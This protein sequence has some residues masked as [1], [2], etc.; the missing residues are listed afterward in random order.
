MEQYPNCHLCC[1]NVLWVTQDGESMHRTWPD[2]PHKTGIYSP[3]GFVNIAILEFFHINSM[4]V[5][6]EDY[7]TYVS[8]PLEFKM[9][10]NKEADD[11]P[12]LLYMAQLGDTYYIS[13]TM[14]HYRP[15]SNEFAASLKMKSTADFM[16]VTETRLQALKA[17]DKY[18]QYKFHDA[19]F[20]YQQQQEIRKAAL[21]GQYKLCLNIG[22]K[23]VFREA[24]SNKRWRLKIYIG[25]YFPWLIAIYDKKKRKKQNATG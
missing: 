11:A 3:S 23:K 18:T 17:Y 2:S 9:I 12:L 14:S 10:F 25:A 20:N 22:D 1:H 15:W 6:Y 8:Q 7:K 16:R 4:F 13:D 21:S 5:R 24:I 19:C